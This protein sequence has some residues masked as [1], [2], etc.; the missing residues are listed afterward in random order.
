MI[1]TRPRTGE[2]IDRQFVTGEVRQTNRLLPDDQY[3][4]ALD[5]LVIVCVDCIPLHDG[6]MLLSHRTCLPHP[7]WWVNGGRMRK[8]ELY[9]E[10]ASRLMLDELGLP[11]APERFTLLGHYSLQWDTRAQV[12]HGNG[13]HTL[14]VV[15]AVELMDHEVDLI[16]PNAEYDTT[17]WVAPDL[18]VES[19]PGDYHPAL[20]AMVRDLVGRVGAR[21]CVRMGETNGRGRV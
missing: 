15:H 5:T 1:A 7:A 21:E 3:G 17:R 12:P 11:L 20:Q 8:G 10:A 6:K 16:T 19:Q 2:Y 18:I 14:S 4:A 13:C 9:G